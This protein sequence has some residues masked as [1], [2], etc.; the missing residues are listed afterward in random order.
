MR[1]S[2]VHRE[3]LSGRVAPTN[4]VLSSHRL[5]STSQLH[6][7]LRDVR[8]RGYATENSEIAEGLR[9][10]GAAVLDAAG[11]PVAAVAV[12]WGRADLD[13]EL[14]A[15]AVQECAAMLEARLKR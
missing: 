7:L 12:T 4:G 6:A 10:V 5:I 3:P 13:E 8:A 14:L 15:A 1:F 2:T 9:S 11:W